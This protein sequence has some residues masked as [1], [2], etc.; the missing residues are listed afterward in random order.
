MAKSDI[1]ENKCN[2]IN[3]Y[4]AFGEWGRPVSS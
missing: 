1:K 4:T 2:V 3:L